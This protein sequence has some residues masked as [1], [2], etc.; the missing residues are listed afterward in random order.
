M[1]SLKCFFGFHKYTFSRGSLQKFSR[2]SGGEFYKLFVEVEC[3]ICSDKVNSVVE[4]DSEIECRM[5]LNK[6]FGYQILDPFQ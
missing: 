6:K 4:G 3:L 5:Q 2:V 1:T